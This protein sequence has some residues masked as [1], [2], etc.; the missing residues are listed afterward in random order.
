M[1]KQW[2][3]CEECGT[4]FEAYACQKRKYCGRQCSG[5]HSTSMK[6]CPLRR[7]RVSLSKAGVKDAVLR[8]V[9]EGVHQSEVARR[10]GVS[11]QRVS[12]IVARSK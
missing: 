1:P 7:Y 4:Y 2:Q 3:R 8:L 10:L 6:T 5:K 11:R 12:Q 9:G